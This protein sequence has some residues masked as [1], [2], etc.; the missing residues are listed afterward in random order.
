MRLLLAE[1]ERELADALAVILKHN[2]YSVDVV[3]NG[4]DALDYLEGQEYDGA[5]LDV[6]MPKMDGLTLLRRLRAEGNAVP[7]LLLTARSGV[8]DRVEGLDSGANDYLPKPFDTRELLARIRVMTGQRMSGTGNLLRYGN[9]TLDR[10][11]FEMAAPGGRVR[12]GNKEFQMLEMLMANPG[13]VIP[14]ERFMERVWGYD[15][16]TESGVVWVNISYLRKKL[17]A[18]G[19]DVRIRA[20]RNQGY[21]LERNVPQ[22]GIETGTPRDSIETGMPQD[23]A[24]PGAPRGGGME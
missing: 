9:L 5:I 24:A 21:A 3:Y 13:Q 12:P 10:N 7:I 2:C 19:A 11:T 14:V 6:M 1:D 23:N 17:A 20:L 4:Q 18:I 15:S 8:E 16:D 22:G